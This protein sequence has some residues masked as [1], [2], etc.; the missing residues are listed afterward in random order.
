[1]PYS[2]YNIFGAWAFWHFG[3]MPENRKT[4]KTTCRIFGRVHDDGFL[5]G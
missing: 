4:P 1:M 3:E 2:T 5:G